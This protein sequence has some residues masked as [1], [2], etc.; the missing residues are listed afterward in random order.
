MARTDALG[1]R[2]LG[3]RSSNAAG[4]GACTFGIAIVSSITV[5]WEKVSFPRARRKE[6]I[7]DNVG[8]LGTA[9]AFRIYASTIAI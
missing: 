4:N 6:A 8:V 9:G 3:A 2:G 1:V 7:G 5:E